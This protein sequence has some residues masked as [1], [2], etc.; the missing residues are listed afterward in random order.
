MPWMKPPSIWPMSMAGFRLVPTS[1]R[2]SAAS[3]RL[4]PVSVSITTSVQAAP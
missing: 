3:T 4:S 2:M 1:C